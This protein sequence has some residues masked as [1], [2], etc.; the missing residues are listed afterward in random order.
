MKITLKE[1]RNL[2]RTEVRKTLRENVA[3]AKTVTTLKELR[4]LIRKSVRNVLK[5]EVNQEIWPQQ[6]GISTSEV[7]KRKV[8]EHW[9]KILDYVKDDP[10]QRWAE[11]WAGH[12]ED[13]VNYMRDNLDQLVDKGVLQIYDGNDETALDLIATR[14]AQLNHSD[15]EAHARASMNDW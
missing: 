12:T 6:H 2:V 13:D 4:S 14:M 8:D 11:G 9:K 3:P 5:E 15:D 1:L 7:V 10:E